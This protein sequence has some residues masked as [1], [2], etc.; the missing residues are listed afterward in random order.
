L[1]LKLTIRNWLDLVLERCKIKSC[2]CNSCT[3]KD[4]DSILGIW[5]Y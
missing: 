5:N 3:I 2:L 4:G 1:K